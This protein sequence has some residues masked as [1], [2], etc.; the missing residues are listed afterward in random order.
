MKALKKL[1]DRFTVDDVIKIRLCV[2]RKTVKGY[3]RGRKYFTLEEL[4]NCDI[5][6]YL[7]VGW[8]IRRLTDYKSWPN[9]WNEIV[10][11]FSDKDCILHEAFYFTGVEMGMIKL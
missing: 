9:N 5:R 6:S 7:D 8:L 1:S 10:G 2:S 11:S 4:I 3:F